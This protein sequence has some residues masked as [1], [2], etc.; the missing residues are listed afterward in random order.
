M[1]LAPAFSRIFL[2]WL[3]YSKKPE[4]PGKIASTFKGAYT[5]I[6]NKYFVDE[7]Y[8]AVFVNGFKKFGVYLWKFDAWVV[9]GFVNGSRHFTIAASEASRLFDEWI[10]D[11][12][13][14]FVGQAVEGIGWIFRKIQTGFV[15]TYAFMMVV[16]FIVLISY[17]IF[18]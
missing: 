4:L 17:Y 1:P 15:Q 18:R 9:D 12:L 8:D 14:N 3:F 2:A 13:V 10:V 16:G 7:V 11:G 5:T 6:Y